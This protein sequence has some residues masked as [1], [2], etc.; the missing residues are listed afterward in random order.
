MYG[1]MLRMLYTFVTTPLVILM[2]QL[3]RTLFTVHR[4]LYASCKFSRLLVLYQN[5]VVDF[6]FVLNKFTI[7]ISIILFIAS[8]FHILIRFQL[9]LNVRF[10]MA[11]CPNTNCIGVAC[12]LVWTIDHITKMTAERILLQ[13]SSRS[14]LEVLT[15]NVRRMLLII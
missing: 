3:S 7:F 2:V 5:L 9:A 1:F 10:M 12:V 13:G 6:V 15:W 4:P 8:C 11:S 14:S